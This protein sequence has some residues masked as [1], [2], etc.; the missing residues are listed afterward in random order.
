[1]ASKGL[2]PIVPR[3]ACLLRSLEAITGQALLSLL[4]Q[5]KCQAHSPARSLYSNYMRPYIQASQWQRRLKDDLI[6]DT[7]MFLFSETNGRT[8]MSTPPLTRMRL[9]LTDIP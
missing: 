6:K 3:V 4:A 2:N 5:R 8:Q 9:L 1:M 7:I